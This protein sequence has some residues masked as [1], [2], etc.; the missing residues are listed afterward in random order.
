MFI[1]RCILA[2][3]LTAALSRAATPAYERREIEGWTV[4]VHAELIRNQA[5]DTEHALQ[6]VREHLAQI[7][8][9]VPA[10]AVM[11]LRKVP[12]WVSPEYPGIGPKAEYHPGEG[13]LRENG[14]NPAMVKGVEFTNVPIIDRETKRMPVFVL[15]ELAHAYHDQVL[16]FGNAEI[17]A[18]FDRAVAAKSYENVERSHVE[19]GRP[20][21]VQ[22]AYAATNEREYFAETTEAFFGRNDFFPFNR[23]DLAKHDPEMF[24]LLAKV[25]GAPE[26][27]SA[28]SAKAIDFVRE[29]QPI[30]REHCIA[31]HGPEK[32]KSDYRLDI[33]EVA[34]RGGESGEAAIVPGKSAESPLIEFV[35]GT[36]PDT[37]M[38]PKKSDQKR[39]S[40]EQVAVLR[41][42]IDQGAVWPDSASVVAKDPRDWWSLKPI[43]RP[44]VPGGGNPIDV[45]IREKLREKGLAPSP[46]A[47]ARTLVRRL[48]FDLTG[49]P[50][51]PEEVDDFCQSANGKRQSAIDA[52][53]DRLLA[54]PRYGERWARHWLDV[55]HYGDTHGYDKDKQRNN[56]W[57]YRDYVIRAFN[58]DKP[59]ARFVQEQI[60]GDV[61]YPGT[62]DGIEALGF[63]AAGPWDLIGHM[64]VPET[65]TDGKIAR[66]LDRDDMVANAIGTFTST[67]IHCAQC[68]NHKFDPISQE[69][70]YSLQAVF[71]ALDRTDRK[72]YPDDALNARFEALQREQRST[73]QALAAL[74]EPLKKQA[75]ATYAELTRR[76]EG[77]SKAAAQKQGN[78]SPDFGYHSAIAKAQDTTKWVQVDLGKRVE[79]ERVT[80]LPCYDDFN[81]IGGGFGFPVRFKI[82]ASDDPEFKTGVTLLWRRHDETFMADFKNPG[83]QSFTT[84][85][86]K[87]D[88]I[89]GRYVRVTATKLAPRKD[90]FILALAELQV[91]DLAGSNV[92]QGKAVSSLDSI[93]APPRWRKTNLT[94][95]IA[96]VSQSPEEKDQLLRERETLLLSFADESTRTKRVALLHETQRIAGDLK[97]LPAPSAVYAGTIHTGTGTFK[98]TGGNS[99]K[100][101]PIF[102]LARGQVTQPG[103]EMTPGTLSALSFQP[104]RFSLAPT[105]PEGER[106]AA[107]ARWI[108]D[109][110]NPLT[111]RSIV[112]R[113]WQYHFGRGLVETANDF[114]RNGGLPSHPELLD[115]LASEFRDSGGSLKKLHR[116]IVTSATYQQA[117]ANNATAEKIDAN[118][119]LLWRQNRRKLEAEAVRDS[120]LAASG[121]L[122]LKMGGPGWQD[123][124]IEHP[125]HSPHYEYG[126]ANPEDAKTWRR[127]IY[128]FI[129]RSQTQPWMTSLDCADPSMRVDRRNESLSA[130][131]ALALLNNGFMVTQARH[132]AERV[133]REKPDLPAQVERAHRL[134]LGGPPSPDDLKKL[135]AFA[136][137]QGLPNLCRV[138]LNLNAFTFVD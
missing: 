48:Y 133:Q 111:W 39:L 49:L 26:A 94:D 131:Q 110:Q 20:N 32:Q 137:A 95:G 112:N 107:L 136:E 46:E 117:S 134:A 60:A 98:G 101:R 74:E 50:P 27:K 61:L 135:V 91:F 86:A 105:A 126:L 52:L 84:S 109:P 68:H 6:V 63:I 45:F 89:A 120:V 29:V 80:V 57:P 62:H 12:L 128:R 85:G 92:A 123:F 125:A 58:E 132:F 4:H 116:L 11:Q 75:G 81:A 9:V 17:K 121:K 106:R 37:L 59:Y 65:K 47:D 97:K 88:G 71:A 30:F 51:T 24:G 96:P 42:W 122:D 83:L 54:S 93:E 118:N 44:A 87:D 138:L 72:Y 33:R 38:P 18:A 41:A 76:I 23:E 2:L 82:E 99:G 69:D 108:T 36:D 129:V 124:V 7:V 25:W 40:G 43:A 79:I 55:V 104:A 15:H 102:L 103:R 90:D 28:S 5:D 1:P 16:G 8:K 78:T 66:H 70:Y 115:W 56:A 3:L 114:G 10:P 64:E 67:T 130:L 53:V 14:R 21:S 34:L 31:C 100:P 127:S 13:W 35:S 22:R 77:A 19:D 73:E 119:T 113:V